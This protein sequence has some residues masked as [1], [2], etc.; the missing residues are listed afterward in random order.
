MKLLLG[1]SALLLGTPTL[2]LAQGEGGTDPDGWSEVDAELVAL[3]DADEEGDI[4]VSGWITTIWAD[5]D[6]VAPPATTKL[7][8]FFF[9]AIRV[10]LD[11]ERAGYSWKLSFD[12]FNGTTNIFDAYV[13]GPMGENLTWTVGRFRA[14]FVRS[15]LMPENRY[16]FLAPTRNGLLYRGRAIQT[17]GGMLHYNHDDHLAVQL[18]VQNGFDGTND[19]H[20][21]TIIG[22]GVPMIEGA[23]GAPDELQGQAAIAFSDD[24]VLPK[25]QALLAEAAFT[26][27]RFYGAFEIADYDRDYTAADLGTG[28]ITVPAQGRGNTTP[29][30]ITGSALIDAADEWE[31][32]VRHEDYDDLLGRE[33]TTLGVNKYLNGHDAKLMFNWLYTN[34]SGA[35]PSQSLIAIGASVS[36]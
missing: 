6:T 29:W 14:P 8:G 15:G 22:D 20:M 12:G 18:A 24:S 28:V 2:T 16:L 30:A 10:E 3:E 34:L 13:R 32:A 7:N 27:G 17:Q 11:G 9:D 31:A 36:F 21:I 1:C 19:E 35:T 4:Q 5:S 26:Y 33:V 25:G 23:Y